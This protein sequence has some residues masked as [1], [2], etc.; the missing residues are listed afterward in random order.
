VL[1]VDHVAQGA[2]LAEADLVELD[3]HGLAPG[4]RLLQVLL[5]ERAKLGGALGQVLREV[6]L[7]LGIVAVVE[8]LGQLRHGAREQEALAAGAERDEGLRG[9]VRPAPARVQ[10]GPGGGRLAPVLASRRRLDERDEGAAVG[11]FEGRE[12]EEVVDR[13]PH[14]DVPHQGL[15]HE[16]FLEAEGQRD[17]QRH[18]RHLAV[19]RRR[20]T[21]VA[22]LVE[23]L[24]V[25]GSDHDDRL[26]REAAM[27]ELLEEPPDVAI[28]PVDRGVVGIRDARAEAEVGRLL[29]EQ[30][31]MDVHVVDVG[32]EALVAV[33]AQELERRLG[34]VEIR[35]LELGRARGAA[36]D[37]PWRA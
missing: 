27:V 10:V 8:E 19:Q 24:A 25:V 20:V 12:P 3:R 31:L 5:R 29:V 2:E 1:V 15:H 6:A 11:A 13:R 17:D 22:V 21:L 28:G 14:V 16:T 34:S 26:L 32:E 9:K 33:A 23:G 7:L 36:L 18:A 30:V 4:H 35:P 37:A